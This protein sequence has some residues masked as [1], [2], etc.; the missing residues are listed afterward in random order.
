[1]WMIKVAGF[2]NEFILSAIT[3]SILQ[4]VVAIVTQNEIKIN[5]TLTRLAGL[6]LYVLLLNVLSSVSVLLHVT[7]NMCS[8]FRNSFF[9]S[10]YFVLLKYRYPLYCARRNNLLTRYAH[11]QKL[12]TTNA[13]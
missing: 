1:M 13:K 5:L 10:L 7:A 4:S 3:R 9:T 11:S 6:D 12:F 8:T 2:S